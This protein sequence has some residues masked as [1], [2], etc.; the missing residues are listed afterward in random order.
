MKALAALRPDEPE[1]NARLLAL[2]GLSGDSTSLPALLAASS[3]PS[4]DITRAALRRIAELGDRSA[5]S[6]LRTR[7]LEVDPGLTADF[8]STL[9]SLDDAEAGELALQ[10]LREG[11]PHRRIAAATALV[12]L[13]V[14]EQAGALRAAL[15]DPLAAVRFRVLEALKR[16]GSEG[17]ASE[18]LRLLEDP[19]PSVRTA[20]IEAIS[21]LDPDRAP[22]LERLVSDHAPQVRQ[23]L[24]RHLGLLGEASVEL[25]LADRHR[26]VREAAIAASQPAQVETL[27]RLLAEDPVVEVRMAAARR[28]AEMGVGAGRRALVDALADP[29]AMVRSAALS[30]LRD[31]LGHEGAL[32][33]LLDVLPSAPAKLREGIVH[34]LSHLG[35]VEAEDV[36]VELTNDPDRDVRLAVV[37]CAEHLFG[38]RWEGLA[39]LIVDRDDAVAN[40]AWVV[41]Q[42]SERSD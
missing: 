37:H 23:A 40:A 27:I 18:C 20:A 14:P 36:L 10:A 29:S 7:M 15:A 33:S 12:V 4:P 31:A 26:A 38:G 8:A 41:S 3:D 22:A 25:L 30:S 35:A 13:A 34:A 11:G 16:V 39:R 9:A 2:R 28:L 42:R 17:D 21:K 6:E 32:S 5:A 1:P 19:D 24:A